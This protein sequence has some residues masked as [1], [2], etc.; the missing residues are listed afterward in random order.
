MRESILQPVLDW[1]NLDDP[2][3]QWL[4]LFGLLGQAVFLGRWIVQWIASERRGESHVPELFWWC[5]LVG[6]MMLFT[7]FLIDHD[8]VGM[9]GQSVGWIVYS[10]NLYLIKAKH[11]RLSES[12]TPTTRTGQTQDAPRSNGRS[13]NA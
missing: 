3:R 13:P 5:S 8:P 6:A 10:R 9:L 4:V 12:P 11:R 7:Y 1:F 2:W